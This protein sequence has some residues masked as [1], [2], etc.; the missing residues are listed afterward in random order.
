MTL[1]QDVLNRLSSVLDADAVLTAKEDLIPYSFD[2]T[3]AHQEMPGAVVFP[4]S[5]GQVAAVLKVAHE[6]GTPVVTRGTGTSLSGGSL[7]VP[8]CVVMSLVRM[9]QI[10]EVDR[11]N[12]TLLTEA[13]ASTLAVAE[14]AEAAGLFYP[15]D[16][17]SMKISS[18]GGN[19]AENSGGLRGLKYGVT[20]N[21]VMGLEVV[22]ADGEVIWTGNKCVKDVAGYSLKDLFVGSEGTLGVITQVL[23]KLIPK[24][25]A[26]RTLVATYARMDQAA[27][28]VSDIIAA[29]II[30]CTLEFL[31]RTTIHCVDD[32]AKIGL[33]R[34]CE[35]LL[36]METDGPAA[37]VEAEAAR[38]E[39][40]ARQNECK[41]IRVAKDAAEAEQ[42]ASARR[43]AF[44]ALA[45]V[46][47]TTILEDV[48]VPR[49][50]LAH[51][52][53]FVAEVA[54]RH[55]LRV[56]TFGHMGDGNL[57][58]TFLTDERD[59][60]AMQRVEAA[61]EEIFDE[62]IRLGGTITGEHGVGVAKKRFLAKQAGE[63]GL[64]VMREL[65]RVLDPKGILNPGK[66]LDQ[67]PLNE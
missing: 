15:P 39:E 47:P 1:A 58:P 27:Q 4:R 24:P 29:Q 67:R 62:A 11:A 36:L 19:V 41:E 37:L 51:M 9:D 32:Y 25:E 44:S 21:Y 59:E 55:D 64:R 54:K 23:L 63:A 17:A 30:P 5:T 45:R 6:S 46:S 8:G 65:R 31:D 34:D 48:T 40:I 60:A 42:L 20:R 56:G 66:V 18:I 2:G 26:K 16:P 53:R 14:A 61:F 12:L 13:G 50:E 38:M 35:A 52:V 7:P 33:P 10:K 43:T 28:T 57:H 22:L 49:S 3:A